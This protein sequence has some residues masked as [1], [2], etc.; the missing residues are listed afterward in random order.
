MYTQKLREHSKAFE[1]Q[2]KQLAALKKGGKSKRDAEDEIKGRMQNKQNRQQKGKK[3]SAAIGD[4][5]DAPPPE[6]L[7]KM[8]EYS[9]K[10]VFPDPPR[11]PPPV[12]GLYSKSF[13][14]EPLLI[15]FQMSLLALASRFFSKMLN[16]ASTWSLELQLLVRTELANLHC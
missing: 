13:V 16:L 4:D 1:T 3:G 8:K 11:L 14:L 9:V 5:D 10:F 6:L 2:Q 12:L 15:I 7:S